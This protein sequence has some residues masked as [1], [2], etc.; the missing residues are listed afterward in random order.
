MSTS[1]LRWD[2]SSGAGH[3]EILKKREIN[4][5]ILLMQ[6]KMTAEKCNFKVDAQLR[7]KMY[8]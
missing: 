5:V 8:V 4:M 3:V 7:D 2:E 6:S 1:F